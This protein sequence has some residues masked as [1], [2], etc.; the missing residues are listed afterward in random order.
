[1]H[2]RDYLKGPNGK[3]DKRLRSLLDVIVE[4]DGKGTDNTVQKVF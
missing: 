4:L 2:F 3:R 1:M